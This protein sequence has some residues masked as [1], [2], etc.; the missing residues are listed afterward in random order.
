[1]G[2]W[3]R[4]HEA[5]NVTNYVVFAIFGIIGAIS[6]LAAAREGIDLGRKIGPGF[7]WGSWAVVIFGAF[8]AVVID[9]DPI[10]GAVASFAI[11][12]VSI[13]WARWRDRQGLTSLTAGGWE[14]MDRKQ[15]ERQLAIWRR[16]LGYLQ[17]QAARYGM[18]VPLRL[19]NEIE[20]AKG[21]IREIERE[22]TA[23][24]GM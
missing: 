8:V 4:A 9:F 10:I 6:A 5:L 18:D 23:R 20:D 13:Y 7:E 14:N 19:H 21:H 1:M 12:L 16:N 24:G 3:L 2:E 11:V 22:L 15:L 17:L